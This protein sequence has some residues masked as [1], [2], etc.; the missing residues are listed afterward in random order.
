MTATGI[1][2]VK[3]SQANR[4]LTIAVPV[5]VTAAAACFLLCLLADV[6]LR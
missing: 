5:F 4:A 2:F 6:L 3:S 1:W